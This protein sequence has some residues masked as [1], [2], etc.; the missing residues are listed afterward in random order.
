MMYCTKCGSD[1]KGNKARCP[2]CGYEVMKM[3]MDLLKPQ[4]QKQVERTR[5]RNWAPPIPDQRKE[6]E[7]VEPVKAIEFRKE[8]EEEDDPRYV[9]GC[10]ICGGTPVER[11]FFTLSPLCK[12]HIVHMQ[13]FVRD[14]AFGDVVP[15]SPEIAKEKQ[16]RTPTKAEAQEAGM[17]F[18]IK[19]YH[20]WRK[21]Q[22]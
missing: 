10:A 6:P 18:A 4:E 17:F 9:D 11:C 16:G 5:G 8:D 1:L 15:A 20:E 3:K 19:P 21:V 7:E 22:K 2:V 14:M 13:I 12:R